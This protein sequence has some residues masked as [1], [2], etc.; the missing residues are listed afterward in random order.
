MVNGSPTSDPT[1][2]GDHVVNYYKSL[3]SEPLSWR[4]RLDNLEFDRLNGEEASGLENPFEEKEVREVIKGMNRD[5]AP[6]PDGFSMAFFP[7]LLGGDQGRFHG[8]I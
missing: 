2:I 4:P 3:F 6:G 1:S 7:G 8:G 5:K